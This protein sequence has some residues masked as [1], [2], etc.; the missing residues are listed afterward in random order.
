V[1]GVRS[2]LDAGR[3]VAGSVLVGGW[4][5]RVGGVSGTPQ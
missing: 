2:G 1:L 5:G 4:L 3:V